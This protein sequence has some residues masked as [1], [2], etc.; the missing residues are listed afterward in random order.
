MGQSHSA[1][2]HERQLKHN[3]FASKRLQP[4][5][6]ESLATLSLTDPQSNEC[7]NNVAR[8][9]Q[10]MSQTDILEY[11]LGFDKPSAPAL[12]KHMVLIALECGKLNEEPHSLLDI[13]LHI[14]RRQMMQEQCP[15]Y[16]P[17]SLN[18]IR[19]I[20]YHHMCIQ[21][22][23]HYVNRLG[24][25]LDS[26]R[27]R[28]GNTRFVKGEEAKE[29]LEEFFHQPVGSVPPQEQDC[30]IPSD[31]PVSGPCPIIILNYGIRQRH[32]L[33]NNL[34]LDQSIARNVV[35]TISTQHIAYEKGFD[36]RPNALKLSQL[37]KDLK[38]DF[39]EHQS[40]ADRAAY[41]LITAI[42]MVMRPK[43]PLAKETIQSVV[44]VTMLHSQCNTPVWGSEH[45]CSSC[46]QHDHSRK[47]CRIM[48]IVRV[49]PKCMKVGKYSA[50][51]FH[52]QEMCP[53]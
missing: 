5:P 13:G 17:H 16:G 19:N 11:C 36:W 44:N 10:D 42:Q 12:A 49:C 37:A 34:N 8:F 30:R 14:V 18:L 2:F 50:A 52:V 21:N 35:A 28:F 32:T 53:W 43:I 22:N 38:I 39:P 31:H 46:G 47:D 4:S 40:A 33:H 29:V 9:F 15:Y 1:R 6:T 25:A 45:Y 41:S 23:A 48:H 26:Q 24:P 20:S 51:W 27:T 3:K 7:I